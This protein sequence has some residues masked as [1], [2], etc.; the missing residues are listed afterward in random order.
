M[1]TPVSKRLQSSAIAAVF[2]SASLGA[3]PAKAQDTTVPAAAEDDADGGEI[4]VTARRRN[5][6]LQDVPQSLQVVSGDL[7]DQQNLFQFE[8][9]T[10]IVSGLTLVKDSSLGGTAVMRGVTFYRTVNT[11]STVSFYINDAPVQPP[12]LF[13]AMFD[14]GQIEVLKGP[15]GTFRGQSAPSGAITVTTRRPDL[16]AFGATASAAVTDASGRNVQGA[17]NLPLLDGRLALRVAGIIDRDDNGGVRSA[18]NSSE[19]FQE[20]SAFRVSLA[21]RPI[22]DLTIDL[23]YQNN[24]T[25]TAG[26]GPALV[27]AGSPGTVVQNAGYALPFRPRAGYNGPVI[28]RGQR[29][30]VAQF[31]DTSSNRLEFMDA[32]ISYGFLGQQLTYVGSHTTY[33]VRAGRIN[34]DVGN[35]VEG[36]WQGNGTD[37][38]WTGWTHELRLSS[39]DRIAGFLDYVVGAFTQRLNQPARVHASKSFQPGAFGTPTGAPLPI[40]PNIAYSTA[41]LVDL[42]TRTKEM[43]YFGNVTAHLDSR[44][45]ISGG[46]RFI[47]AKKNLL[48]INSQSAG[49][50]ARVLSDSACA[51]AGGTQG[52]TYAGVCDV[53]VASRITGTVEEQYSR[54]ATVYS[55]SISHRITPGL[56]VYAS[57]GSSYRPAASQIGLVNGR[58]DPVLA[59]FGQLDD[60]T[61]TSYEA[62]LKASLLGGRLT[63]NAAYYHQK[64]GGLVYIVPG[65]IPYLADSAV[66][67]PTVTNR[68]GILANVDAKVDGI[69]AELRFK[70]TDRLN[71]GMNVSWADGRFSNQLLPCQDGNF[72]GVPDAI[73]ATVSQFQAADV[74]IAQCNLSRS[75]NDQP[76]WNMT[77]QGDYFHPI[78]DRIDGF[79]SGNATYQPK[80][81]NKSVAYTVPAYAL[82]DLQLGV[83]DEQAGWELQG[84]VRNLTNARVATD[85]GTAQLTSTAA[86]FFGASGY[87]TI[88]YLAPREV[89][90]KFRYAFGSR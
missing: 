44:T 74:F 16:N 39:Q 1:T 42:D 6:S 45:E 11:T 87:S 62:G 78:T 68:N 73:T 50:A 12:F 33:Q 56:L 79:I 52:A 34:A 7:L 85:I 89:G 75:T 8:D 53:P 65:S 55:A 36:D 61:S 66:A 37:T 35:H 31:A 54:D 25:K 27:G 10:K 83:R 38:D 63:F 43:S 18:N 13:N 64:Y 32:Q 76:R 9:L 5:E 15:Q 86:G 88:N 40:A 70:A 46:V 71:L 3:A 26:F 57:T 23:M 81:P 51:S 41:T 29:L 22:D 20:M 48:R 14:I 77:F 4:I 84:F 17:V 69:D 19:P 30:A 47:N 24:F 82:I 67:A 80:N 60:E 2:F 90:I 28:A 49:L 72:D 21:A 59:S 58:N